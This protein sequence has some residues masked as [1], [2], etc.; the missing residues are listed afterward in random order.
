VVA[1]EIGKLAL[2]SGV[3]SKDISNII[4]EN[5]NK[6]QK[7]ITDSKSSVGTVMEKTKHVT[8]EGKENSDRFNIIFDEM[9]LDIEEITTIIS[10]MRVSS[11]EH[12]AGI[13]ELNLVISQLSQTA[14]SNMQSSGQLKLKV[15]N[16]VGITTDLK[17][18]VVILKKDIQVEVAR[19]AFTCR[20][21]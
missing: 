1:E 12:G 9:V 11:K 16:L 5:L 18:N 17:N 2:I 19:K 13:K 14:L 4:S 6:I 3:A 10:S 20:L 15:E 21:K 8:A 7:M